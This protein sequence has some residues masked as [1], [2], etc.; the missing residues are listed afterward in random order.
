MARPDHLRDKI[1]RI[2]AD[3]GDR[4]ASFKL[5]AVFPFD[6]NADMHLP[7]IV[8]RK[9]RVEQTEQRADRAARVLIL[10]LAQQQRRTPF[11][12]PQIHIV[13]RASRRQFGRP[14]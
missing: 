8:E 14:N 10:G 9:C 5:E 1:G 2:A 4:R 13:A 6:G 12:I 11:D 7:D 3:L